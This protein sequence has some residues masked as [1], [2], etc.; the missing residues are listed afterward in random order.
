MQN[1][2][3]KY[4]FLKSARN[5]DLDKID[6]NLLNPKWEKFDVLNF[7]SWYFS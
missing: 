3:G 6:E 2:Y 1:F 4:S 7:F 5:M